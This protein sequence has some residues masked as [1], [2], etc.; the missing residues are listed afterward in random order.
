MDINYSELNNEGSELNTKYITECT[1]VDTKKVTTLDETRELKY[2]YWRDD[3]NFNSKY[4]AFVYL[5]KFDV[6]INFDTDTEKDFKILKLEMEEKAKKEGDYHYVKEEFLIQ[7]F[8]K[9]IKCRKESSR[10][11]DIVFFCIAFIFSFIGYSFIIYMFI[12]VERNIKIIKSVF[13]HNNSSDNSTKDS[14]NNS[15]DEAG[16]KS[17]KGKKYEPLI[18]LENE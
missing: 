4:Y 9:E 14:I 18:P 16:T 6:K 12:T 1:K 11:L 17:K 10:L 2:N 3:T 15:F 7:G 13:K 8:Q 5:F